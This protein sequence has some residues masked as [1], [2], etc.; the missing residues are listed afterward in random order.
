MTRN[1][2]QSSDYY[3]SNHHHDGSPLDYSIEL[4]TKSGNVFAHLSSVKFD[5][6]KVLSYLVKYDYNITFNHQR[7]KQT[8]NIQ[9]DNHQC[10]NFM[11]E[12]KPKLDE[13]IK[14]IH[15]YDIETNVTTTNSHSHD[16]DNTG[17]NTNILLSTS[18]SQTALN[19]TNDDTAS[20][21]SDNATI[22]F[23]ITNA[24]AP[25]IISNVTESSHQ[26]INGSTITSR[27]LPVINPRCHLEWPTEQVGLLIG[28]RGKTI[29]DFRKVLG[30]KIKVINP[31]TASQRTNP[32]TK[33][34]ISALSNEL[35]QNARK[36]LQ[37][38]RDELCKRNRCIWEL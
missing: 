12:I 25:S 15:Q 16:N 9:W 20:V 13:A 24:V 11:D 21:V 17:T 6:E 34:E 4:R 32:V 5:T 2:N 31:N 3:S 28:R 37:N 38:Y 27:I 30:C 8:C 35:L 29:K 14:I 26:A 10:S 7:K 18:D 23:S 36:I 1:N 19:N 22:A 33:V